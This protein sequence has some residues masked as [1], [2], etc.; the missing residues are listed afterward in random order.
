MQF[1]LT[2]IHVEDIEKSVEFYQNIL[3]MEEIKRINPRPGVGLS[4]L[5]DEGGVIELIVGEGIT[6][7]SNAGI[8]IGFKVDNMEETIA[9]LNEQGIELLRGPIETPNGVKLAF[10]ADPNGV[11]VEFI[12][13]LNL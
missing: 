6:A 1:Q 13:G 7:D 9:K 5:E 8:S 11:E 12:A 10:I 4:F 3:E 2:T